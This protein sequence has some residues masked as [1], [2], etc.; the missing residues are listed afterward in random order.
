MPAKLKKFQKLVSAKKNVTYKN[1]N[2]TAQEVEIITTR[3]KLDGRKSNL[4]VK[5]F[6]FKSTD[7]DFTLKDCMDLINSKSKGLKDRGYTGYVSSNI[8]TPFSYKSSKL[9]E[10]G[11]QITNAFN[12]WGTNNIEIQDQFEDDDGE[13][14][15]ETYYNNDNSK[16]EQFRIFLYD[17]PDLAG[18]SGKYNDCVFDALKRAFG[19]QFMF[20]RPIEFKKFLD[21]DRCATVP[22]S[23]MGK[24]ESKIRTAIN[25][26]GDYTRSSTLTTKRQI[27]LI[28]QDGHVELK[29]TN[30]PIKCK[31]VKYD[32]NPLVYYRNRINKE[33][34]QFNVYDGK[35]EKVITSEEFNS[36]KIKYKTSPYIL[37]PKTKKKTIKETYDYFVQANDKLKEKTKKHLSQINL[38][39]TGTY[40]NT[41][42]KLFNDLTPSLSEPEDISQSEAEWILDCYRG[43]MLYSQDGYEGELYS[44]DVKA[45]YGYL[46][47]SNLIFPIKQGQFKIITDSDFDNYFAYGIYRAEIKY[48]PK[49]KCVFHFNDNNKYTYQDMTRARKLNL[50][51]EL[52]Q[53]GKPNFLYYGP[54]S[55]IEG[56]QLF[57]PF[58]DYIMP[59]EGEKEI[60]DAVKSIRNV[61]HGALCEID[62]YTKYADEN[63]KINLDYDEQIV[64]MMT[65]KDGI[66]YPVVVKQSKQFKTNYARLGPFLTAAGRTMISK[67]ITENFDNLD[68][69]KRVHTDGV[70]STTKPKNIKNKNDPTAQIGDVLYENYNP[71]VKIINLNTFS[72]NNWS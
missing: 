19:E 30:T 47:S 18:C 40:K 16:I 67:F 20:N 61:L 42:I 26:E 58:I 62:S 8:E 59:L 63:E 11:Y 1:K 29:R 64:S 57:K 72:N 32:K 22:F 50:D 48:N 3:S 52:I 51:I 6:I 36:Y 21:I 45:M 71:N 43:G 7:N 9:K 10:V 2:L 24:I 27:N 4:K 31:S 12:N 69:V 54:E 23:L 38:C 28:W 34:T 13:A 17:F 66:S 5:E 55:R 25:I 68:D 37:I 65:T 35:E 41:A 49:Y 60:K 33:V 70:K 56:R 15:I 44:S 46:Q 53:D 39:K 14:N